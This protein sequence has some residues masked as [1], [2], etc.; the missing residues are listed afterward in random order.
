VSKKKSARA[1]SQRHAPP[2]IEL[3]P[4][5]TIVQAA[6]LHRTMLERLEGGAPIIVDGSHVE[7][8]DTAVLQ[9]LTSLWR[10]GQ[11][12]GITCAWR[13]SSDA[14]RRTAALVGV[15]GILQL[16]AAA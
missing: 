14:L 11:E 12:R 2:P 3:E 4:R 16:D 8:I 1:A 6:A 10:T 13:G 15:A 9:L 5:L 7:E